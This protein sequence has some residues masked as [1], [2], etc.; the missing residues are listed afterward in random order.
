MAGIAGAGVSSQILAEQLQLQNRLEAAHWLDPV[1]AVLTSEMTRSFRISSYLAAAVVMEPELA[2]NSSRLAL[3]AHQLLESEPGAIAL[4]LAP[5]GVLRQQIPPSTSAPIGLDLLHSP[6]NRASAELAIRTRST[7]MQGPFSLIQGGQG[8]VVRTPVFIGTPAHFW[9]FASALLDWDRLLAIARSALP[10]D[11]DLRL[12]IREGSPRGRVIEGQLPPADVSPLGTV[13]VPFPQGSWYLEAVRDQLLTSR[14]RLLIAMESL[15]IGGLTAALAWFVIHQIGQRLSAQK[16][17]NAVPYVTF[18][19]ITEIARRHDEETGQHMMRCSLYAREMAE[20]LRRAGHSE[21]KHLSNRDIDHMAA[22]VPL[23][24]I[25]KVGIPDAILHKP[26]P[27]NSAEREVMERH[28]TLG[29]EVIERLALTLPE[30]EHPMMMMARHVAI[31]H[32]ENWDGSGYPNGLAGRDIP[33]IARI[34]AVIDVY[35]ALISRRV[36]KEPVPHQEVLREMALLRGSKFDPDLLDQML[37]LEDEFRRI[38]GDNQD[39]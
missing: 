34:M 14:Q 10:K 12:V 7:V 13:S 18:S 15:G 19:A 8:I 22:A 30:E 37:K 32:H 1:A 2:N 29:A 6:A 26:G 38:F 17:A 39:L 27:L 11:H 33:L 9:G 20:A 16:K 3:V 4:Q 25:G 5:G 36:Y 28:T 24:D 35:D 21:A 23:H 31:A